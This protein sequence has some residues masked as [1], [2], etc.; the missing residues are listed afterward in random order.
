MKL[1]TCIALGFALTIM[2]SSFNLEQRWVKLLDKDLSKWG[3][4]QSYR[5]QNG[6]KGEVLKDE[7]GKVISPVGHDKNEG[8]VFSVLEENGELMLRI[9]GEIYGCVYTRQEFENYHLRLKYKWGDKKWVPR[10]TED[11]DSGIIYH[12]RGEAGVDYWKSWMLGQEFQIIEKSSGDYWPISSTQV[13]IRSK[14][15]VKGTYVYHHRGEPG[16][17]GVNGENGNFCQA[18]GNYDNK[19]GEWNTVELIT[20]GDKSLHIVNGNV[21]MALSDSKYLDNNVLKPLTKGKLQLQSE[22]A[23]VF[24]KD[25]E[26]KK[27]NS[28]P[29]K[30]LKYFN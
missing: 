25:I 7:T 26:I 1:R 23:E 10:M 27:I 4:Y 8:N 18:S 21:A 30:Y 22:A 16:T 9:S 3:V 17:F 24:Y 20:V 29:G 12:S 19:E 13:N 28:I 15:P 5:H 14:E 6:Y 11:K 2:F